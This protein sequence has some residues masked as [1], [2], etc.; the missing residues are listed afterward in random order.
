ME[1]VFG[2]CLLRGL[3]ILGWKVVWSCFASKIPTASNTRRMSLMAGTTWF[4]MTLSPYLACIVLWRKQHHKLF[5]RSI[6]LQMKFH[7]PYQLWKWPEDLL[8]PRLKHYGPIF[9]LSQLQAFPPPSRSS[10][11]WMLHNFMI[12]IGP[13]NQANQNYWICQTKP[14]NLWY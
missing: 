3:I 13:R 2:Q 5:L 4:V 6:K 1:V 9:Q 14:S 7:I 11:I 10:W 12:F 8:I